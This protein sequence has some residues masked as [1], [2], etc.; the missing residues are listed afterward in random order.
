VYLAP[1]HVIQR[2]DTK[3]RNISKKKL[4][5]VFPEDEQVFPEDEQVFLADDGDDLQ[6]AQHHCY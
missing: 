5:E 3:Q 6:K 2:V 1:Q 4:T